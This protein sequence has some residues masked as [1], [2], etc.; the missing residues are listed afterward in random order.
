MKVIVFYAD[1]FGAGKS[2]C[3]QVLIDHGFKH[4]A[5]ATPLKE[6]LM[7]FLMSAG[8][9]MSQ[10]QRYLYGDQK[11]VVVPEFGVT[12]R[13]MMQ[14]LG[15]EWGRMQIGPKAW[16]PALRHT[17]EYHKKQGNNVVVDDVR[18]RN[19][20][21]FL[22]EEYGA[23]FIKVERPGHDSDTLHSSEGE[24][25]YWP[26]DYILRNDSTIEALRAKLKPLI[27]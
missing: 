1:Q 26:A 12:G 20:A 23:T 5:F 4:A 3:A 24:L 15:T 7:T 17:L 2:T 25:A 9:T 18:H 27:A 19:E 21:V 6:M 11:H 16:A 13:H 14:A 10:A 22:K 8:I